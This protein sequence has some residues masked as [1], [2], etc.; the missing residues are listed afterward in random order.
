M[1]KKLV[2][3]GERIGLLVLPFLAAGLVL[4]MMYPAV[5][6]LGGPS[7]ALKVFSA[8]MLVSGVV[9]WIWSVVLILT[10]VPRHELITSGPFAEV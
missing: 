3:S 4:N 10:K 8:L 2:G 6:S 9:V 5:F 7:D 1:I